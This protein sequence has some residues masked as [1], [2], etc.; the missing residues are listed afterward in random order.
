MAAI[1]AMSVPKL[2]YLDVLAASGLEYTAVINGLF[3]DYF[4]SPKVKTYLGS[5]PIVLDIANNTAAIPASGDVPIVFTYS[6][7]IGIFV[8]KLLGQEQWPL[9]SVIIGDK[10]S[11]NQ[12]LSIAEEVKG[13]K[14]SIL[15][16]S[17]ET[18]EKGQI[19]E[20]PGHKALYPFLPKEML[21]DLF[22]K[23]AISTERGHFNVDREGSLNERF[24]DVK[25][26]SART[27]IESWK[28][29]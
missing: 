5:F 10:L 2:G 27:I 3:L 20:L 8:A 19:T 25:P 1:L 21:Q 12:F 4:A 6:F 28:E 15:H 24:P 26:K 13:T 9:E 22:A 23:F 29:E 17:I 7:D 11:W 16:D 18:L 14:F